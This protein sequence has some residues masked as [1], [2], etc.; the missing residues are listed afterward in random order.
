M[1]KVEKYLKRCIDSVINQTYENLEIILIDDGSPDNCGNIC[2]YY[3]DIDDRIIVCHQKNL[4]LSG[5]RNKGIELSHGDYIGF[6]DSDDYIEPKL[7]EKLYYAIEKNLADISICG[8]KTFGDEEKNY[9]LCEKIW[10]KD[11]ALENLLLNKIITSHVWNKLFKKELF[12]GIEFDLGKRYEDVRIMHK[13]FSKSNKVVAIKDSLYN[14]YIRNDSITGVTKYSNSQE[15]IDSLDSRCNDL[16]N[17]E[18]LAFAKIGEFNS[19]RRI[20]YEMIIYKYTDMD[21]YKRMLKKEKRLYL[22]GK[23]KMNLSNRILAIFFLVTPTGYS[24]TRLLVNKITG[25]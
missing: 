6:I 2:D 12:N 20:I 9:E 25:K 23:T 10:T 11:Q 13:L 7:F 22:E 24:Y 4:G 15:F 16:I 14:Y 18:Q 8:F 3:A 21:F 5:A 17:T 19:I 1:Y